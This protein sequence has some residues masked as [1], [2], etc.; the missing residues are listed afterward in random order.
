M[1]QQ[2]LQKLSFGGKREIITNDQSAN[3]IIS[4][5]LVAHTKY[6]KDYDLIADQFYA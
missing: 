4:A 1:R 6:Q 3:D 2:L 5:M